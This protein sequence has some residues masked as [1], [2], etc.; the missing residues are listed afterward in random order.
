MVV[1]VDNITGLPI[2][3]PGG[4]GSGAQSGISQK[5][6]RIPSSGA[7]ARNPKYTTDDA[8]KHLAFARDTGI[9]D[10][11]ASGGTYGQGFNPPP[12]GADLI[13]SYNQ[14]TRPGAVAGAVDPSSDPNLNPNLGFGNTRASTGSVIDPFTGKDVSMFE[15]KRNSVGQA[16]D[17]FGN[18][19]P[20][21]EP[22][23]SGSPTDGSLAE[24]ETTDGVVGANADGT[25]GLS[26]TAEGALSDFNFD[27]QSDTA[28]IRSWLAGLTNAGLF[29]DDVREEPPGSG[30]FYAYDD[31][32]FRHASGPMGIDP[33]TEHT[34]DLANR[35]VENET[36]RLELDTEI[37]RESLRIQ[38]EMARIDQDIARDRI[39]HD[40]EI[41]QGNWQNALDVQDRIDQRERS[42]RQLE[43]DLFN[44]NQEL[45]NRRFELDR[46]AF[47]LD[48]LEFFQELSSSPA[49]FADLFNISRG[50]APTGAGG[51]M[52]QGVSRIGQS[53]VQQTAAQDFRMNGIN[54]AVNANTGA[55]PQVGAEAA[56]PQFNP[57]QTQ[58]SFIGGNDPTPVDAQGQPVAGAEQA[59]TEPAAAAPAAAP[60]AAAAPQAV[61]LAE[62]EG[63]SFANSGIQQPG[64][65][66]Q[67]G[68][69]TFGPESLGGNSGSGNPDQE[70]SGAQAATPEGAPLP[71]G[72]QM[73]F[74]NALVG[75]PQTAQNSIPLLSPQALAQL[76]PAEQE[77]YYS[78]AQ[79]QGQY[80]PDFQNLLGARTG[81]T[82]IADSQRVFA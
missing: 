60:A 73:A 44:A 39:Q 17:D 27:G 79:M 15:V 10:P 49:N 29:I 22:G 4:A 66:Q 41:A 82:Q 30:N 12:S 16:V 13:N 63:A 70:F 57:A 47:D 55:L 64:V 68:F 56:V 81:S 25:G 18:V 26:V 28:A 72:L 43:R 69:T 35:R 76:T 62:N 32:G 3:A 2:N 20:E 51:P 19:I 67:P 24:N 23:Q 59:V 61:N 9:R 78:L 50:L 77:V 52:P 34:A 71:P 45:Q 6:T 58:L 21:P 5:R 8:G 33:V 36:A 42:G 40:Q 54:M 14:N 46:A 75:A 74:N 48:K 38:E 1:A 31:E 11:F 7:A 53:N 37:Q 65:Q 80:L